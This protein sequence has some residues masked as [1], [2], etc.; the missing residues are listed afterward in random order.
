MKE[1]K[2]IYLFTTMLFA[3]IFAISLRKRQLSE[4]GSA[5]LIFGG[6]VFGDHLKE[7]RMKLE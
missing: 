7:K 3:T 5:V 2:P 1:L 4:I 6:V